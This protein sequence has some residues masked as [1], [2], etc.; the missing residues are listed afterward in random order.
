MPSKNTI[1]LLELQGD[2]IYAFGDN[3][4]R[5]G[6]ALTTGLGF[7][8][9]T[10]MAEL[11]KGVGYAEVNAESLAAFDADYLFVDFAD[12][13]KAQYTALENNPAWKNLKAVKEGHVV[14]MDYDKS[15][16]LEGQQRLK[17]KW[18]SIQTLSS[19]YKIS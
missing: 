4:A 2:K 10:K 1:S 5:G 19:S 14:T 11:S 7:K 18:H 16:S 6:Q 3:F 17:R 8:Q 15:T 9:S 12:K 13:D